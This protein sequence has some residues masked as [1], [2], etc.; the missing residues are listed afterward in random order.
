MKHHSSDYVLQTPG[1]PLRSIF[2]TTTNTV[3]VSWPSP[4]TGYNAQQDTNS[5]S[6]LKQ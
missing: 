6:S 1:A 3:A 4:S 2:H 5:V